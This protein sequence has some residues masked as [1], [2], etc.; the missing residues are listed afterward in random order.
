MGTCKRSWHEKLKKIEGNVGVDVYY[1]ILPHQMAP[2]KNEKPMW[3]SSFIF[4]Q[5]NALVYKA[6]NVFDFL[7]RNCYDV[8]HYPGQSPDLNT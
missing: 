1:R 3:Q 4:M 2:Y 5:D 6:N 7:Q 8:L